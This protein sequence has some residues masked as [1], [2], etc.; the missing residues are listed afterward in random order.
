MT[1]KKLKG[2]LLKLGF[3][4]VDGTDDYVGEHWVVRKPVERN[5]P[6]WVFFIPFERSDTRIEEAAQLRKLTEEHLDIFFGF[7]K[8]A[9]KMKEME[10]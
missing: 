7:K 6:L 2:Y 4:P 5:K 10:F 8:T 3:K 1:V 9:P